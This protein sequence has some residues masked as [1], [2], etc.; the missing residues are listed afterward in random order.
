MTDAETIAA[1][2]ARIAELE[3]HWPQWARSILSTLQEFGWRFDDMIDLPEELENYLNGYPDSAVEGLLEE[4]DQL[5]ADNERLRDA[6]RECEAEIDAYIQQEYPGDHPV[7]GRY[8]QR[9]F[10][11]N[12]A[13]AA[14]QRKAGE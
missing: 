1:K 9:D 10:A 4:R 13:R 2:D 7:Q 14:L 11:S 8:R 5:R 3:E 12:P 6:L